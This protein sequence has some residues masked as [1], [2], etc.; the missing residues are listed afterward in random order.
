MTRSGKKGKAR[1][2]ENSNEQRDDPFGYLPECFVESIKE[3]KEADPFDV[4]TNQLRARL[5]DDIPHFRS[6]LIQGYQVILEVLG[7]SNERD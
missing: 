6:K 4:Y 1:N 2:S 5:Y 7:R 3:K